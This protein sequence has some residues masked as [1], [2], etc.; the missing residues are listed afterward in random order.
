MNA[1]SGAV[2]YAPLKVHE[3]NPKMH[4]DKAHILLNISDIL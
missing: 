2:E 3:D 4:K 1:P